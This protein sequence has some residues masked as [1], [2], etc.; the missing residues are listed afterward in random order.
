MKEVTAFQAIV[1]IG[2]L[3][4][5]LGLFVEGLRY[6]RK[7]KGYT[8]PKRLSFL[9]ASGKFNHDN[10]DFERPVTMRDLLEMQKD[11]DHIKSA[12]LTLV[13][14]RKPSTY[15]DETKI[16]VIDAS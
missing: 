15:T 7:W 2:S 1:A 9:K 11:V 5:I 13:S 12:V 6:W 3:I 8:V 16:N 10:V 4:L 14:E